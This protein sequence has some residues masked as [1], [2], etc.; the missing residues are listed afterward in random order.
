M[1]TTANSSNRS[2]TYSHHSPAVGSSGGRPA[3][4]PS[5]TGRMPQERSRVPTHTSGETAMSSPS[6]RSSPLQV[7]TWAKREA[8]RMAR[9]PVR[10]T[11]CCSITAGNEPSQVRSKP[12]PWSSP[13]QISRMRRSGSCTSTR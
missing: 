1:T 5:P 4:S 8:S 11:W 13:S 9:A 10:M 2:G 7:P 3:G 12:R 6:T